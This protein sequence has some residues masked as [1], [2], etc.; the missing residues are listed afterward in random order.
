MKKMPFALIVI[1]GANLGYAG[2][3][4]PR[5]L[6]SPPG[7]QTD[8]TI[9]LLWDKPSDYSNVK[10]YEIYQDGKLAGTSTR[11]NFKATNLPPGQKHVFAVKAKSE[12][13]ASKFS[14]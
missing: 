13:E 12:T 9:T 14:E 1:L 5:N 8:S 11:C 4:P 6:M 3:E 10:G 2:I 7:A